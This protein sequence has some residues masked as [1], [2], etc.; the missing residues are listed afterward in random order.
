[1]TLESHLYLKSSVYSLHNMKLS[2]I[3]PL[4][5]TTAFAAPL[6]E[7]RRATYNVLTTFPPTVNPKLPNPFEFFDGRSV[8]TKADFAYNNH[9]VSAAFHAQ[10]LGV[11]PPKPTS[12]TASLSGNT[13]SITVSEAGKSITF[14]VTIQKPSGTE[15]SRAIIAYGAASLPIPN[16]IATVVFSNDDIAAQKSQ[17][18][19]GQGKFYDLYGSGYS[20][21][22][23][24]AWV[25]GVDR[26]IDA[27]E[28][29]PNAGIDPKRIRC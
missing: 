27:L 24:T 4:L 13:L 22:A 29:T 20:T 14:S 12:V 8:T 10:E 26:I 9:E 11:F 5:S 15:P 6:V 7:G 28:T 2:T 1:M 17:G 16:G 3:I 25:W 18:S 21:G 19:R 23:L